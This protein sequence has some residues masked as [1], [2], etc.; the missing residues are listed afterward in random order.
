M[1]V[2]LTTNPIDAKAS[3][4]P[5]ESRKPAGGEVAST[6]ARVRIQ[7]EAEVSTIAGRVLALEKQLSSEEPYDRKKVDEIKQAIKEGRYKI[8]AAKIADRLL[9]AEALL[10]G[11]T[12]K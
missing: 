4:S 6:G 7:P 5:V 10:S 3:A 12:G 2:R 1:S 11:S 8:N 9:E